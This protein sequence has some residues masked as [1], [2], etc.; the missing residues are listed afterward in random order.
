MRE[1]EVQNLIR[2]FGGRDMLV[3]ALCITELPEESQLEIVTHFSE[4][5]FKHI[6][7]HVPSHHIGRVIDVLD[8]HAEEGNNFDELLI[9]LDQH[10]PNREA[11][12]T[13]EVENM[14]KRF[15]STD[16]MHTDYRATETVR[17]IIAQ[18]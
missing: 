1:Y 13:K 4:N 11:S 6:L 7:L 17:L 15:R 16:G 3:S 10:I 5:I 12:V 8:A 9:I 14:I 2:I 18:Q